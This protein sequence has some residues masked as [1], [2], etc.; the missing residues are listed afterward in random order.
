MRHYIRNAAPPRVGLI[1]LIMLSLIA[2]GWVIK[3]DS[4]SITTKA[5][6]TTKPRVVIKTL[7]QKVVIKRLPPKII[8]R[9]LPA[10]VVVKRLPPKIITRQVTVVKRVRVAVPGPTRTVIKYVSRS[11]TRSTPPRRYVA[12]SSSTNHTPPGGDAACIRKYE[13]GGDYR[14]QNPN[15]TASGAYQFLDTT[16]QAVTGLPG[17]AKDYPP[18]VQDRAFEKLWAGGR[19]RGQ[20]EVQHRC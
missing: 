6:A 10:R 16:W 13:S 11:R 4:E 5:L 14:A 8:T 7:P 12:P 18:S 17:S 9:Q 15:S 20:W 1:L 19:N 3:P 2:F